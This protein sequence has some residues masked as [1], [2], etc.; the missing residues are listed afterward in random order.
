MKN[1]PDI[2][3]GIVVGTTD[4]LPFEVAE[5]NR[6]KLVEAY[7]E[8]Y[9]QDGI[10]EC[11]IVLTDNE[12]NIKRAM[13]DVTK[14]ECNAVALYWANYGPESAGTLFAQKFEGPV[15]M[16]AAAEEGSEPF[17]RQR[18]DGMSGFINACYALKLRQANVYIPPK[19]VGTIK[20]CTEM[21]HEFFVIARTLIAVRDLKLI[22]FGPRPSSYLASSAPNHLLYDIG[23]EVSEYSELELLDS[24]KKHESDRRIEKI[25]AEMEQRYELFS[26]KEFKNIAAY[27]EWVAKENKKHP[28][29]PIN[30]MP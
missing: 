8:T 30:V 11:S 20:Q 7:R 13:R 26:E 1:V 12:V 14:A 5:E 19:P 3:L 28:E 18:L 16:F 25:V 9:G 2:K 22:S 24:F 15:M 21:I 27:N 6:K 4:W 10:Y 17:I 29:S 23:V